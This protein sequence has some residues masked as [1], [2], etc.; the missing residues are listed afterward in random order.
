MKDQSEQYQLF[1]RPLYD[2]VPC[3][4]SYGPV[5]FFQKPVGTIGYGVTRTYHDTNLEIANQMPND[6][7]VISINV[8]YWLRNPNSK[9]LG[10]DDSFAIGDILVE[11]LI[12]S[13]CPFQL[14]MRWFVES[15]GCPY[16][17]EPEHLV[18]LK[19]QNF[20]VT[21]KPSDR[22]KDLIGR[23]MVTLDGLYKTPTA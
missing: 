23:V 15:L 20:C 8:F 10:C 1:N 6:F 19:N 21:L 4:F 7:E 9:R 14:P 18:I 16:R 5:R 22:G 12:G 3:D 11:F 13:W 17:F 2:L